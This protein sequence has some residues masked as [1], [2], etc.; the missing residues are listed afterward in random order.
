M[1][2][3]EHEVQIFS[4]CFSLLALSI[5]VKNALSVL[6]VWASSGTPSAR[7]LCLVALEVCLTHNQ[8]RS[9][10]G[11]R[12]STERVVDI[13]LSGGYSIPVKRNSNTSA[14]YSGVLVPGK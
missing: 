1:R 8:H 12:A 9:P 2:R 11:A 13:K 5:V 6:A 14:N 4:F 10:K 7:L 3:M